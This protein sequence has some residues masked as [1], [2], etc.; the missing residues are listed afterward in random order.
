M[1]LSDVMEEVPR[2]NTGDLSRDILT[3]SVV[4]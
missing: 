3:S 1:E 4:A 2:D